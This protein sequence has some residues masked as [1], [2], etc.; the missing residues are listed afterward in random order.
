MDEKCQFLSL[1]ASYLPIQVL[2]T[3]LPVIAFIVAN[4]RFNIFMKGSLTGN[5]FDP[6]NVQCSRMCGIPDK[7]NKI[8]NSYLANTYET[9]VGNYL[10]YMKRK[11]L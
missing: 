5:W 2:K 6:H 7:Q 3:S 8:K 1:H 10:P 9:K 11:K 4:D